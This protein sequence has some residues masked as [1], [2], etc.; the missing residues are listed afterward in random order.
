MLA[1][2]GERLIDLRLVADVAGDAPDI[3]GGQSETPGKCFQ[4]VGVEVEQREARALFREA[5]RHRDAE[6]AGSTGDGDNGSINLHV[7]SSG[8]SLPRNRAM[9]VIAFRVCTC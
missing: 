7:G 5:F 9:P 1:Y 6:A 3:F 4:R 2:R 8:V